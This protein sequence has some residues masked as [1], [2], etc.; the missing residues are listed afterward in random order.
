M[1][2]FI[3]MVTIAAVLLPVFWVA[4]LGFNSCGEPESR[5]NH[6]R[7]G[8]VPKAVIVTDKIT[9]DVRYAVQVYRL[10][11]LVPSKWFLGETSGD[12]DWD[13]CHLR[14]ASRVFFKTSEGV[15][16]LFRNL[17]PPEEHL[18]IETRTL[19]ELKMEDL[20]ED[21]S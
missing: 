1:Q 7:W 16:K 19:E 13:L 2:F 5:I 9:G 8:L 6:K 11:G 14:N 4:L 18:D 20:L 12:K 10:W 15:T 21:K 3:V 17:T